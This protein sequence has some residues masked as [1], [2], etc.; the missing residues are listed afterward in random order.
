MKR[1]ETAILVFDNVDVLDFT[2]PYEIFTQCRLDESKRREELSPFHVKIIAETNQTIEAAGGLKIIPD[3]TIDQLKQTDILLIPGG[4][5]T[6]REMNN[7][8][9]IH[10]L[11]TISSHVETMCSVCTGAL[12]LGKAGLLNQKECTTH[13]KS[14]DL[15]QETFPE[16]KVSKDKHVIEDENLITSAGVSAGIDLAL[17]VI[18]RYFNE[19]LAFNTAKHIEYQWNKS[20]LRRI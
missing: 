8:S 1:I 20:N 10:W 9:L 19:E 14:L 12:L 6:R 7:E 2:G 5:G 15:L 16:A 17:K 3:L 13:W 4:W 11:K 18:V